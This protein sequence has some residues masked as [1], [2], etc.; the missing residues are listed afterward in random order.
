FELLRSTAERVPDKTALVDPEGIRTSY[1]ELLRAVEAFSNELESAGIGV[2]D[3]VI[4]LL[5]NGYDLVVSI[6]AAAP[7]RALVVPLN[8]LYPEAEL[9]FYVEDCDPAAAITTPNRAEAWDRMAKVVHH[10]CRLFTDVRVRTNGGAG[11]R[12]KLESTG[13][14][15]L[16]RGQQVPAW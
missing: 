12:R 14:A 8:P 7:I 9:R 3:R 16:R 2:G 10:R 6:F 4:L 13:R 11:Q 5:P 15:P 1:G